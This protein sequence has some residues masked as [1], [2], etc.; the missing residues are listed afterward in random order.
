MQPKSTTRLRS[1]QARPGE[2][3][4]HTVEDLGVCLDALDAVYH[5][6]S[7][8]SGQTRVDVRNEVAAIGLRLHELRARLL[9]LHH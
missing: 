6:A 7:G 1:R 8:L 9:H 3:I 4:E 5:A 2:A